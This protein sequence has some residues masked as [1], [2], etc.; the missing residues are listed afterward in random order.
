MGKK[1]VYLSSCQSTNDEAVSLLTHKPNTPEGTIIITDHQTAGRGQRGNQWEAQTKQNLTFS[2]IVKP[3]FL[4]ASQQFRLNIAI[5]LA[6]AEMLSEK[7]RIEQ[8]SIKW[9]NDIYVGKQ[10]ICGILIE[11]ALQ[12]NV[13]AHSVVGIGLNV[14]QVAFANPMATSMQILCS[15]PFELDNVLTSLCEKLEKFYLP[16]RTEHYNRLKIMYLEKLYK[17]GENAKFADAEGQN[18]EGEIIGIN[19]S[20]QLAI[21]TNNSLRYFSFKELT[22]MNEK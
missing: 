13:I 11:N 5:T 14:N 6:I 18:F 15:Q 7:Y 2:L 19:E 12:G 1:L 22:Y 4:Q 9:P 3:T 8:V 16:L 20:G 21:M 17:R 10:K